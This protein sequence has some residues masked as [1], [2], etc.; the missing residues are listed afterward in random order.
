MTTHPSPVAS[1]T[2]TAASAR[3]LGCPELLSMILDSFTIP[4]LSEE[5]TS[6]SLVSRIANR[7]AL[8]A[9]ARV[10][11]TFSDNALDILW[12]TLDG[13]LPLLRLFRAFQNVVNIYVRTPWSF[14]RPTH[15]TS[16]VDVH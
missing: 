4:N 16:I 5:E 2:Q 1:G 15:P 14:W 6:S 12:N 3:V 7:S 9:C 10:S 8:A 11:R 13:L